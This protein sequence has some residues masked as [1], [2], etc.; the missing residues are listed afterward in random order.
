MIAISFGCDM[1][2]TEW[3]QRFPTFDLLR[4]LLNAQFARTTA[5]NSEAERLN[6]GSHIQQQHQLR[7][8]KTLFKVRNDITIS[9]PTVP[10]EP[11]PTPSRTKN[12]LPCHSE[13]RYFLSLLSQLFIPRLRSFRY[14]VRYDKA[15]VITVK[16]LSAINLR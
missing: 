10:T 2:S 1:P 7:Q 8:A 11:S 4:S 14:N 6:F 15:T 12:L 5:I 13:S 9:S 3:Q 16:L